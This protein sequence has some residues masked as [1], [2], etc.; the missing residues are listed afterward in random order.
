MTAHEKE[1]VFNKRLS[2]M[3]RK[4]KNARISMFLIKN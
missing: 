1:Q 2:T 4:I 3:R